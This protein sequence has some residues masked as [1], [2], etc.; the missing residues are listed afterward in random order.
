MCKIEAYWARSSDVSRSSTTA[1]PQGARVL[2]LP[3]ELL[4]QDA[5][6]AG[7]EWWYCLGRR[8]TMDSDRLCNEL[9][10]IAR[11]LGV[12]VRLEPFS[13]AAT[14]GGGLCTL[15]GRALILIDQQ[16]PLSTRVEVLARALARLEADTVYMTPEARDIVA[17]VHRRGPPPSSPPA[18]ACL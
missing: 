11:T 15:R 3:A 7:G 9:V 8:P 2:P 1:L 6:A 12:E 17:A 5:R 16:A 10:A 13:T 14:S 18:V 4:E